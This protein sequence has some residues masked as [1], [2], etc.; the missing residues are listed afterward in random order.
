MTDYTD[1]CIRIFYVIGTILGIAF[2]VTLETAAVGYPCFGGP[3]GD[4]R[5]YLGSILLSILMVVLGFTFGIMWG[6]YLYSTAPAAPAAGA[7]E[8][9]PSEGAIK[10]EN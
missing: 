10:A 8:E 3:R 6:D 5:K 1:P 9:E 4:F 2:F 7:A